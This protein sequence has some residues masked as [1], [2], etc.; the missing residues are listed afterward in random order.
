MR[1]EWAW[2][3]AVCAAASASRQAAS[4]GAMYRVRL[5]RPRERE[6][7]SGSS[8][9]R[10]PAL[11][12]VRESRGRERERERQQSP[13]R[14][15]RSHSRP[16]P[17][18]DSP[19]RSG[20]GGGRRCSPPSLHTDTDQNSRRSRGND[21][22]L[23]SSSD[24]LNDQDRDDIADGP[25]FTRSLSS[26]EEQPSSPY[27]LRHEDDYL[28]SHSSLP[29]RDTDRPR[30]DSYPSKRPRYE[31]Q[32]QAQ[33]LTS[34]Y[35]G[36]G[37]GSHVYR[38]SP[39]PSL[40]R[41][42]ELWEQELTTRKRGQEERNRVL[43][44]ESSGPDFKL[45]GSVNP[46]GSFLRQ[47]QDEVQPVPVKSILK[48][49]LEPEP[50]TPVPVKREDFS[51]SSV[52]NKELASRAPAPQISKP[53]TSEIEKFLNRFTKGAT[54][55]T[56]YQKPASTPQSGVPGDSFQVNKAAGKPEPKQEAADR[57]SDFL[58][59]HERAS[60]DGSGFS[61]ILGLMAD[62]TSVPVKKP[63]TVK[64][65]EDE[66]KFL[67]GDEEEEVKPKAPPPP[68]PQQQQQPP[69]SSAPHTTQCLPASRATQ[70]PVVPAEP[71]VEE[72]SN[73]QEYEQ[74]HDLLKT[75]GLDI[76]VAE[77]GKLAVRTQ[78]RLHGK[79]PTSR[80]PDRHALDS[81]RQ[82]SWESRRSRSDTRSPES[83]HKRSESPKGSSQA[84][85]DNAAYSSS[86]YGKRS[87][88]PGTDMGQA[89][90][91]AGL[92]K[93][94]HTVPSTS[95][96]VLPPTSGTPYQIPNYAQYPGVQ[97]PP[98][99][100][101]HLS[102]PPPGFDTY[103]HYLAYASQT[104]PMYPSSQQPSIK[105]PQPPNSTRPNLRVIQPVEGVPAAQAQVVQT[106]PRLLD[107]LGMPPKRITEK[108]SD[109]KNEAFQKQ[110]VIEEREKLR[111]ERDTQQK[112]ISYLRAELESLR[113]QQGELLRKKRREKDGHKD[114]LLVEVNRL[115][116]NII[117]EI[118]ELRKM[119][120]ISEKKQTELDKIAQILGISIPEK[121]R[122]I[123]TKE[124]PVEKN[125]R[126]EKT[127]SPEKSAVLP[128]DS[129]LSTEKPAVK[130]PKPPE[131][132]AKPSIRP[133]QLADIYEYYDAG[134]HW[135]KD[136]NT[137]CGTLFDFFTHMHNKK[138]RQTLDP[139]KRPW[140]VKSQKEV[141]GTFK[142][143]D[144]LTV[145]A[146]G[147]E[148]LIPITGYFCQLCEEFFGD[149]ICAEQHV[150]CYNHNA[151]YKKYV[152]EN[153]LY[154]ARRSLDHQAGL[155]VIVEVDR[156][157]Q[158]ELKRKLGDKSTEEKDEQKSKVAKREGEHVGKGNSET[159]T[160]RSKT[161]SG[162]KYGKSKKEEK[163]EEK[164]DRSSKKEPVTTSSFGKFTWKK[165]EEDKRRGVVAASTK[166]DSTG[167]NKLEKD[168]EKA[169]E[170]RAK[171][172]K[173]RERAR[174]ERAKEEKA[175]E[176]RAR[177]ERVKESE[178]EEKGKEDKAKDEN[179][180]Q[181]GKQKGIE[182]KLSGKTV[183][184]PTNSGKPCSPLPVSNPSQNKIRPNLPVPP[185]VLRKSSNT[186][187][188]KPA[189]LNTFLSIQS[190]GATTKP[191]PVVKEPKTVLPPDIVSKA[192][193]GQE[194]TLKGTQGAATVQQK[195][196]PVARPP[197]MVQTV[198]IQSDEVAP[199]VSVSDQAKLALRVP[200]RMPP[201]PLAVSTDLTKIID[202][203][204]SCLATANAKDLY[205]IFY[206]NIGKCSTDVRS[207]NPN[208]LGVYMSGIKNAGKT[209]KKVVAPAPA[210][211]ETQKA[212]HAHSNSST[213][214]QEGTE[215]S[216]IASKGNVATAGSQAEV[217]KQ[218]QNAPG[219]SILQ[220]EASAS[221]EM[222]SVDSNSCKTEVES[223]ALQL[224]DVKTE[225]SQKPQEL[226]VDTE[227]EKKTESVE[228]KVAGACS[229]D[230]S[231]R[232]ADAATNKPEV[233]EG[234]QTSQAS[235]VPGEVQ[236]MKPQMKNVAT[237]KPEVSEG[238]QTSQA[239]V[240]PGEVQAMKPQMKNVATD[241]PEV[242]KEN[243]ISQAL[244]VPG[245]IQ[246]M[247]PQMKNVATGKPGV[248]KE[249]KNGHAESQALKPPQMKK[250]KANVS[251]TSKRI[252]EM[253]V[254]IIIQPKVS[255]EPSQIQGGT[256]KMRDSPLTEVNACTSDVEKKSDP[257]TCA[258]SDISA[259]EVAVKDSKTEDT[260]S[261]PS[262]CDTSVTV[263]IFKS[264]VSKDS[265][266]L[267]APPIQ[268]VQNR[269][270]ITELSE[271]KAEGDEINL[272][273]GQGDVSHGF[274]NSETAEHLDKNQMPKADAPKQLD[275]EGSQLDICTAHTKDE[276]TAV[277]D[278]HLK[279]SQ[280]LSGSSV[281]NIKAPNP[282]EVETEVSQISDTSTTEVVGQV[283]LEQPLLESSQTLVEHSVTEVKMS[284]PLEM[285]DAGM[286]DTPEFQK[287]NADLS[288]INP[289]TSDTTGDTEEQVVL[290][291][292]QL[293]KSQELVDI[294]LTVANNQ[295]VETPSSLVDNS[296]A[297]IKIAQLNSQDPLNISVAKINEQSGQNEVPEL[298][299]KKETSKQVI[300]LK[301]QV[302]VS[303]KPQTGE[304]LE[305][306]DM[307]GGQLENTV[308]QCSNVQ[309]IDL[310]NKVE[311]ASE[312]DL[313]LSEF[314][315]LKDSMEIGMMDVSSTQS[316]VE[317]LDNVAT[318]CSVETI[319][320]NDLTSA[321]D[322]STPATSDF[323]LPCSAFNFEQPES[324]DKDTLKATD[325]KLS[326][327]GTLKKEVEFS[328]GDMEV[329]GEPLEKLST[330][331]LADD[332]GNTPDLEGGIPIGLNNVADN[333]LTIHP[334]VA[335]S[336]IIDLGN[337]EADK[338]CMPTSGPNI[339]SPASSSDRAGG[340]S[341]S[342]PEI[343]G[344][345]V[346]S[347]S[348]MQVEESKG[349][350]TNTVDM[351]ALNYGEQV[352]N[353]PVP[354]E[355]KVT[356]REEGSGEPCQQM[357]KVEAN[358]LKPTIEMEENNLQDTSC[359]SIVP[360]ATKDPEEQPMPVEEPSC[361]DQ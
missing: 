166:W 209:E 278:V 24:S 287:M 314:I 91:S 54:A 88:E 247:K 21:Q 103:G 85:R 336:E 290:P 309:L 357:A 98:N 68:P 83:S 220:G 242:S 311:I 108:I 305:V 48:K 322:M 47:Q 297:D 117:K 75:I 320:K 25:I 196:E 224:P 57:Q 16:R 205:G 296:T 62:S 229:L 167:G 228:S 8:G 237:D 112:K 11:S 77:I 45:S 333:A 245:Q 317:S 81:R 55:G 282:V 324:D 76:G 134:N 289:D 262:S 36:Y 145:P 219:A 106:I 275:A 267:Q 53:F 208:I 33:S 270:E 14:R 124:L 281:E 352:Q 183:I 260:S 40:Y 160:T 200:P 100:G 211:T 131:P 195:K 140:A 178:K 7:S 132:A 259:L 86:K 268:E 93:S 342:V 87:T 175:R 304:S 246:A 135:C 354:E 29:D 164:E 153:P 115:Q 283:A 254:E 80:S 120:E 215:S 148:F 223:K 272:A 179:K 216:M 125:S 165:K 104:W 288:E 330:E 180:V 51:G 321:G 38:R 346:I 168:K 58:L 293:E 302:E 169:K 186:T 225:V 310:E 44:H 1:G 339:P 244:V 126:L 139:Y 97:M 232:D 64:E 338:L 193:G 202:K 56:I 197:P 111:S 67:Y 213:G 101:Q 280:D 277:E 291:D 177:E 252:V 264:M 343:Q 217:S 141:K 233:S 31:E 306:P 151:K 133:F 28:R 226:Q 312:T 105:L 294:S 20:T 18:I 94:V 144:R 199:G 52:S 284:K 150:K 12:P 3:L 285:K 152:D 113:K 96:T 328:L 238:N 118:T 351:P 194:V 214:L 172:E 361:L 149:Q 116:D 147:S 161:E 142:P 256:L 102:V 230:I 30:V 257:V 210:E 107:G 171:E 355:V 61:R 154:E 39:S 350:S 114:P 274:Q 162:Q 318:E 204:K 176:E 300:D 155:A 235:V 70:A 344:T 158:S 82:E 187:A 345:D 35:K 212:I 251:G 9:R 241:K 191:L 109:E 356:A 359:L 239:S 71:P 222:A 221:K 49:R 2:R 60:Q 26:R 182:I 248:S 332:V 66:E 129:K 159:E 122:K 69:P 319:A 292:A 130:G 6:R 128:K 136:C 59:P 157:R 46:L 185:S 65:I 279:S 123:D 78:E 74:I 323:D 334:S 255:Q 316:K 266:D 72:S 269:S 4:V 90:P 329:D 231:V 286:L 303:Q 234:N 5:G 173:L 189:P 89:V 299:D 181:S 218:S 349:S 348:P 198:T 335:E 340:E 43:S 337:Q 84:S 95:P 331:I 174:E 13:P 273:S 37:S 73:S 17:R 34:D 10:S 301:V 121:V 243:K 298:T 63:S 156:R 253:A 79:K 201:P 192:F 358:E 22:Y 203:P 360:D 23:H 41:R 137:V 265:Q 163:K 92:E 250:V 307:V 325:I 27:S 313:Q 42:E 188:N 263:D 110:K 236:A 249:N 170:E 295:V 127:R 276:Q 143:I 146:K 308:E 184:S 258:P 240:V 341:T 353:L 271:S 50:E 32:Q 190:T 15:R 19:V 227:N 206:S 315:A 207:I 347:E 119:S 326:D 99:Y 261:G 138:H 327:P